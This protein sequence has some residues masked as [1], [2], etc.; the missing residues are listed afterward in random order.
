[1]AKRFSQLYISSTYTTSQLLSLSRSIS[2]IPLYLGIVLFIYLFQFLCFWL[3]VIIL[4]HQWTAPSVIFALWCRHWRYFVQLY[5]VICYS[6]DFFFIFLWLQFIIIH[7]LLG[8]LTEWICSDNCL[9]GVARLVKDPRTLRPKGFGFVTF[10]SDAD[11]CKALKAMNGRVI[12]L[13]KNYTSC[14]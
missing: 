13:E 4:H 5:F 3:R 2:Y 9:W 12:S 11:A 1:M 6:P 8:A 7:W 14:S 10:E